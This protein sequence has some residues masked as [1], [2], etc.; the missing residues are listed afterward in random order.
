[1]SS[2]IRRMFVSSPSMA[3]TPVEGPRPA[4]GHGAVV[5]RVRR[6]DLTFCRDGDM[7]LELGD[8]V[9]VL[10]RRER[11]DAVERLFRRLV[12]RAQRDRHSDLQPGPDAGILV[13]IVPIPLG[14]GTLQAGARRRTP[15]RGSLLGRA[16]A[17]RAARLEP[18]LQR[19]PDP[20]PDGPSLVPG[21]RRHAVG[22][23]LL[24]YLHDGRRAVDS[25]RRA[26]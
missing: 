7:M 3:G 21:R 20:A 26:R 9:R 16:R 10:T 15:H 25:S 5:T 13:G 6:G 8:R 12:S 23:F 24:V 2:T 22:L 14:P 19:Q 11:L 4:A 1:M 18:A 17:H